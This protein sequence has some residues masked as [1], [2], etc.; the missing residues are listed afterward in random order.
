MDDMRFDELQAAL[1]EK[2]IGKR[3]LVVMDSMWKSGGVWNTI[4]SAVPN[5]RNGSRILITCREKVVS[6]EDSK[7]PP[8]SL[9]FLDDDD[10][11]Q[12]LRGRLFQ[13]LPK[14]PGYLETI[15]RQLAQSCKGLPL[16]IA[17]LA[18][19]LMHVELS[20]CTWSK[21]IGNVNSYLTE[22]KTRCLDVMAESYTHLK[23][24]F[25][26]LGLFPEGFEIPARQIP[27]LWLAEGFIQSNGD[28]R[29]AVDIAEDYLMELVNR[30]LVH[31]KTCRIHGML[32]QLSKFESAREKFLE[33]RHSD[34]NDRPNS[35]SSSSMS[36]RSARRLSIQVHFLRG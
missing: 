12:L 5:H 17:V 13:G 1:M 36:C 33:V 31:V 7:T 21:Y 19:L 11:W 4:K 15:G 3:Y 35:S 20:H 23:S 22:D 34:G 10:S 24:C 29:E 27:E 30:S 25:L 18:D 9:P 2:P 28:T 16:S 8:Y 32:R 14:C 26:S 6:M